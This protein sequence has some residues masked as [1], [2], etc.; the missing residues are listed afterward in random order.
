MLPAHAALALIASSLLGLAGCSGGAA[1]GSGEDDLT[2]RPNVGFSAE[3]S[4]VPVQQRREQCS[5][6]TDRV[7]IRLTNAAAAEAINAALTRDYAGYFTAACADHRLDLHGAQEVTFNEGN[8]LTV[9]ISEETKTESSTSAGSSYD[10]LTF[11]LRTGSRIALRDA[12][13]P[14][15]VE[16]IVDACVAARGEARGDSMGYCARAAAAAHP[17]FAVEANGIRIHPDIPAPSFESGVEGVLV[18]WADLAGHIRHD[19]IQALS[20]LAPPPNE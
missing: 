20:A 6:D 9:A 13:D 2:G 12:L 5:I 7:E 8:I 16:R 11:D 10:V 18:R 3:I 1:L 15:G 14:Q 4:V 17:D 19:A